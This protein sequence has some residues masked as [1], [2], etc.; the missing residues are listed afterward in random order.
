MPEDVCDA[1]AFPP[2]PLAIETKKLGFMQ[3][4]LKPLNKAS[5]SSLTAAKNQN[6]S[7]AK[8]AKE[9]ED[10]QNRRESGNYCYDDVASMKASVPPRADMAKEEAFTYDDASGFHT[11]NVPALAQKPKIS[12]SKSSS[13]LDIYNDASQVIVNDQPCEDY[14]YVNANGTSTPELHN[15]NNDSDKISMKS[16]VSSYG[17]TSSH[18]WHIAAAEAKSQ[19]IIVFFDN[20]N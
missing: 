11:F 20:L 7:E 3:R 13:E 2:V 18:R 5:D 6:R 4:L 14:E 17:A 8:N 16:G 19:V 15:N 9:G 10:D 12:D 1:P